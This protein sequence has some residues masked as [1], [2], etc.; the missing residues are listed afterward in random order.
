MAAHDHFGDA[1]VIGR[2]TAGHVLLFIEGV[3]AGTVQS[4]GGIRLVAA[5]TIG[6]KHMASDGLGGTEP[7]FG[8][9]LSEF[10]VAAG[11]GKQG[12]R[13]KQRERRA[14]GEKEIRARVS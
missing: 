13:A 9:G 11:D 6:I 8:V 1:V 12:E 14:A 4:M 3:E 5:G 10:G 2:H 7:Q